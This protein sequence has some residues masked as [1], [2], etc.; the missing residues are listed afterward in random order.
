MSRP[1]EWRNR[2]G[3]LVFA[4]PVAGCHFAARAQREKRAELLALPGVERT[5]AGASGLDGLR[6][7]R[8]TGNAAPG[9]GVG[10]AN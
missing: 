4:R 10:T 5:A 2:D 6:P 3:Q 1:L 7:R 9:Y 8:G